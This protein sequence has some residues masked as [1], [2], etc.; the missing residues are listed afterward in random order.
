MDAIFTT[1]TSSLLG[2]EQKIPGKLGILA[3]LVEVNGLMKHF[4]HKSSIEM[5]D[6]A[7]TCN[8]NDFL[9]I[10]SLFEINT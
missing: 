10:T 1:L 7:K 9:I 2:V 3:L 6:N 4:C 8:N 5:F